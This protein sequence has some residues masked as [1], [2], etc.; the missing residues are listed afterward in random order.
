[1]VHKNHK[2]VSGPAVSQCMPGVLCPSILS[3]AILI[4]LMNDV[5]IKTNPNNREHYLLEEDVRPHPVI[6]QVTPA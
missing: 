2:P 3:D 5:F 4:T 6:V 1:M